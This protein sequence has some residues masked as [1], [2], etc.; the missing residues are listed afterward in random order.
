MKPFY[1]LLSF[2]QAK[3]LVEENII[4]IEQTEI[5][6]VEKALG[7]VMAQDVV[8]VIDHPPFT[9]SG[10]DGYAVRARDTFGA[11]EL[12]PKVLELVGSLHAGDSSS[13][14]VGAKQCIQIATGARMPSGADAVVLVEETEK[15]GHQVKVFKSVYPKANVSRRGEDISRGNIILKKESV[16]HPGEIG[17][18]ASQGIGKVEV[19]RQPSVAIFPSGEEVCQLGRRLKPGQVYDINSYTISAIV[20]D[21]GG[22]PFQ[23]GII[24]DNLESL[25]STI[26]KAW[27]YDLIIIS[28]GSS[29]G[30]R[31]LLFRAVQD[32]GEILFHGVQI[33]PGKPTLFGKVNNKPIFGMPGYPTSCLLN[34]YLFLVPAIRRMAHLPPKKVEVVRARLSKRVSGSLGRRQFLTVRLEGDFAI[35]VYKESGA[36]TSVSEA[37]GYIEIAENIDLVEKDR[38]VEVKLF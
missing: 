16:L 29:V 18:L 17:V 34:A 33:K 8:A 23:L 30:E 15:D 1:T 4:P 5:V 14:K 38:E 12:A 37:D 27:E 6:S 26:E 7:R 19:Y 22:L 3:K 31:D 10:M 28:G 13:Q 36:I 35:P 2:E 21:N 11:G 25:R 9:R 20:M 32:M 24:A